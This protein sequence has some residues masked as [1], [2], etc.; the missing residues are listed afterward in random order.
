MTNPKVLTSLNVPE[1]YQKPYNLTYDTLL[2]PWRFE[3]VR[4]RSPVDFKEL[5]IY[6]VQIHSKFNKN[7]KGELLLISQSIIPYKKSSELNITIP[8]FTN[9]FEPDQWYCF[10]WGFKEGLDFGWRLF[11][12]C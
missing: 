6:L 9:N 7:E 8:E 10:D 5:G 12:R 2:F 1:K 4:D 11:I 3:S